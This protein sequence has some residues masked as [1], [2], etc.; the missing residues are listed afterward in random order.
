MWQ[1]TVDRGTGLT[2]KSSG[3]EVARGDHGASQRWH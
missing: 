3:G 1:G 2:A